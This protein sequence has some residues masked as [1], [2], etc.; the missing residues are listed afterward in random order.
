MKLNPATLRLKPHHA[1]IS[2]ALMALIFA[3][4]AG[5]LALT[6]T[7]PWAGPLW[8]CAPAAILAQAF[9]NTG[10]FICAHDAMHGTL[11]HTSP[12]LNRLLGGL[13]VRCYALFSL[14][15]MTHYHQQHHAHMAT[16]K[17]PDYHDGEH[18]GMLAWYA[19]FMWRY[20]TLWQVI[21]MAV[22]FN[23]LQHGVGLDPIN[24]LLFWVGPALLSTLQLFY[25]GTYLPHRVGHNQAGEHIPHTNA[26]PTWLSLLTCYHF[27]Y[28]REHHDHPHVP[29]WLLPRLRAL[30]RHDQ[31]SSV[32]S[33]PSPA[34]L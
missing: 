7:T 22:V 17:D 19:G 13:A 33:S 16:D 12:R 3:C 26:Y 29:W 30:R 32:P 1:R 21:G 11:C 4:W 14:K 2:A 24:L 28:H 27:G 34:S 10:L 25:F 15:K 20:V 6:L 18:D 31:T 5:L 23:V 9:L 8:W